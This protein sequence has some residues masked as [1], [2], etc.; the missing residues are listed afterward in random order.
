M[1]D[2]T[3]VRLGLERGN[4]P[5]RPRLPRSC[6]DFLKGHWAGR[7][8]H[9]QTVK[10]AYEAGSVQRAV[11]LLIVTN[12]LLTI[13][14]KEIDPFE[15]HLQFYYPMWRAVDTFFT[16]TFVAELAFNMYGAYLV[17]FFRSGWNVFDLIIVLISVLNW[18]GALAGAGFL[19]TLRTFRVFRL[20]KR[21]ESLNKVITAL[22][23][24]IP[25][26]ANAFEIM[27]LVMAIYAI[28]GVEIYGTFGDAGNFT[29]VRQSGVGPLAV[30]TDTTVT[31]LSTRGLPFGQEYFG[32]FSRALFT[33]FQVCT[34]E[35]WAEVVARPIIFGFA[36]WNASGGSVFFS[37]FLVLMQIIFLNV[38]VA[39]LLDKFVTEDP[40]AGDDSAWDGV[41]DSDED[42][43]T[44]AAKQTVNEK[45][46]GWAQARGAAPLPVAKPAAAAGR[47]SEEARAP[48]PAGAGGALANAGPHAALHRSSPDGDKRVSEELS[49][50]QATLGS[51]HRKLEDDLHAMQTQLA[52][53]AART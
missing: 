2:P 24:A 41:A 4:T 52:R 23:K 36:P 18:A 45:A 53:M 42:E 25:G 39:V 13:I 28:I 46:Q 51:L 26:M 22:I 15:P 3:R 34:G 5:R 31:S 16:W 12:F 11:A 21:V 29:T 48:G 50:M 9:Q 33:V 37:T 20:F 32:S 14:E 6:K 19:K 43:E 1:R 44:T 35:S 8:W 40:V 17:R 30:Y 47:A 49:A 27:V 38:V 10:I 7:L